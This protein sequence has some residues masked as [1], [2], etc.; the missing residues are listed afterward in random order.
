[1]HQKWF[2]N[3]KTCICGWEFKNKYVKLAIFAQIDQYFDMGTGRR[4]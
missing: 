1:M 3:V 4:G 2:I